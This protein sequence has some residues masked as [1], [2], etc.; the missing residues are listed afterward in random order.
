M[1]V[2]ISISPFIFV[3][4]MKPPENQNKAAA[5]GAVSAEVAREGSRGQA[6]PG[7]GT[8]PLQPRPGRPWLQVALGELSS[9][10]VN[11]MKMFL[12][13]SCITVSLFKLH[14]LLGLL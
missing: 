2:L 3:H 11:W 5:T 10:F 13:S 12:Y 6:N 4:A 8:A 14:R 1:Y 9:S 7:N